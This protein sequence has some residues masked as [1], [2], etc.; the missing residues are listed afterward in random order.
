MSYQDRELNSKG[1]DSISN[2]FMKSSY[3]SFPDLVRQNRRVVFPSS[4]ISSPWYPFEDG[5]L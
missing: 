2:P 1:Y 4:S 5:F 3:G